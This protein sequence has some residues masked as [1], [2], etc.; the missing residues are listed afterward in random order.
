LRQCQLIW[1]NTG[2]LI[3][4]YALFGSVKEGAEATADIQ[5]K[6]LYLTV[7]EFFSCSFDIY[8]SKGSFT[9]FDEHVNAAPRRFQFNCIDGLFYLSSF[10]QYTNLTKLISPFMIMVFLILLISIYPQ[11]RRVKDDCNEISAT[12]PGMLPFLYMW[13]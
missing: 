9:T 11:A 13:A 5:I 8:L 4:S 3:V 2:P 1:N 7:A 10:P 12:H 6:M